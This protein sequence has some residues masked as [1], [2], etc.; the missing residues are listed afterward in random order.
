MAAW[1]RYG[2]TRGQG[3]GASMAKS[4]SKAPREAR[5]EATQSPGAKIAP[6]LTLRQARIF[7]LMSAN[8]LGKRAGVAASTVLKIEQGATPHLGTIGKL[9][10]ALE[11]DAHS[12]AWPG[13]PLGDLI[14]GAIERLI[15]E[16]VSRQTGEH[17]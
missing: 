17:L 15:A 12:I 11:L 8:E 9:A 14:D 2:T 3:T 6:R 7:R 10:S 1:L 4:A 13:D 5:Q 16:H